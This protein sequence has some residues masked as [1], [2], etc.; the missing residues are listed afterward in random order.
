MESHHVSELY[1]GP[2]VE[3]DDVISVYVIIN[4]ALGMS[5][6]K[7]AAQAFHCGWILV[8]YL[9]ARDWQDQGRRVVVRVA[10]TQHVFERVVEEC[11]GFLQRDEGL[12]EVAHGAA[13]AFVT[14]PYRRADVPKILTHK[15]CQ[16]YA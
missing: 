3:S 10:E 1:A 6:G 16:L 5:A 7:I 8:E 13:T 9:V 4:G 15:R 14:V 11:K 12:T 2:P